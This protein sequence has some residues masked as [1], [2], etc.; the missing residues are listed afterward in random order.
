MK[1]KLIAL[2]LISFFCSM[3]AQTFSIGGGLG[4][5]VL[6][7][8][9]SNEL[10]ATINFISSMSLNEIFAFDFRPGFTIAKDYFGGNLGG[11]LKIFP[12]EESAYLII[13]MKWHWNRG[14]S[15]TG[16]GTRNDV[17]QLPTL[18]LGFKINVVSFELLYEKPYPDGLTWAYIFN[19]YY[20]AHNFNNILSLNI[21][22][23]FQ[24]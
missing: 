15:R 22:L 10:G 3:K 17:F 23:S 6:M 16:H 2:I 9:R 20:Y 1:Q 5:N 13:G 11:Y 8:D 21:G 4:W 19:Q 7:F 12:V 24:L 14:D 18:G